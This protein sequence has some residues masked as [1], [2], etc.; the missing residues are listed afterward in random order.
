VAVPAVPAQSRLTL[1][2]LTHSY[3]QN[4][5]SSCSAFRT[6]TTSGSPVKMIGT[7]LYASHA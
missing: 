4:T 6:A 1:D 5:P 7:H 3:A 2:F